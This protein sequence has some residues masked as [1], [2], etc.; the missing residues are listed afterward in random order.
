VNDPPKR[1]HETTERRGMAHLQ[2]CP[3][4]GL[5]TDPASRFLEPTQEHRC[6]VGQR[7]QRVDVSHQ[8]SFCLT[9]AFERCPRYIAERERDR[10]SPAVRRHSAGMVR[11]ELAPPERT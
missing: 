6:Y 8:T 9:T 3:R 2:A 4:L 5:R 10:A 7:E 11:Q 1:M